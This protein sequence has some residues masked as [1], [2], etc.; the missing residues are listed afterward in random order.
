MNKQINVIAITSAC[1]L[2]LAGCGR[3]YQVRPLKHIK[4]EEAHFVEQKNSIEL[5]VKQLYHSE[6]Q[7]LFNNRTINK[8][9]VCLALTVKNGPN[10]L[11]QFSQEN[12]TLPLLSAEEILNNLKSNITGKIVLG[13]LAIP[14]LVVSTTYLG[15]LGL[16][17]LTKLSASCAHGLM[18]ICYGLSIFAIDVFVGA[19]IIVGITGAAVSDAAQFNVH[20]SNDINRKILST[21]TVEPDKEE[22]ALL[23]AREL[24]EQFTITLLK[25]QEHVPFVIRLKKLEE[26][27][28]TRKT[29]KN[30]EQTKNKSAA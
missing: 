27:K 24:P 9:I 11:A 13:A 25:G 5:R 7:Q 21:L 15:T 19:P 23:F 14:L 4:R 29:R 22:T 30:L 17:A 8:Q 12:T 20:L 6:V 3:Q 2:L 26:P 18:V 28:K 1:A 10:S 16:M